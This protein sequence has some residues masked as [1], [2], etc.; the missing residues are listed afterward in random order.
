M[1]LPQIVGLTL[2]EIVGDFAFKEYANNG[3]LLPLLG[4][5]GGYIGV[6]IMLVISLQGSTVL[7]VNGA[8]DGISAVIES[9]FAFFILGERFHNYLQYVGL[10]FICGG[11]YLL[12]IPLN[13]KNPFHIPNI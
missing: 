1:S 8:W 12:K 6:M 9:I 3:G 7:M 11:L 5:I 4:G 2:V 13:K 10:V